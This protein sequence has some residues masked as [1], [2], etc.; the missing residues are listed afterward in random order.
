MTTVIQFKITTL[1]NLHVG[2]G[3]QNFGVVDNLVQKDPITEIPMINSS[4][5]K[6]SIRDHFFSILGKDMTTLRMKS[7]F[8]HSDKDEAN[9]GEVKFLQASL[10]ALP[11]RSNK[12]LYFLA[13]TPQILKEYIESY[14]ILTKKTLS[15]TIPII[16]EGKSI[17]ISTLDNDCYVEDYKVDE[18]NNQ[19][20]KDLSDKLFDGAP[21]A[22]IKDDV[23]KTISLPIITRNKIAKTQEDDNN[24]FY[25]E[26]IP[27]RTIF[28]SYMI[29][30]SKANI[31]DENI[32]NRFI[33]FIDEIKKENIQIGA[34]ASIGYGLCRFE[35]MSYE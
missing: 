18:N 6:G 13:T 2:S 1:S 32:K 25:E 29:T 14:K 35:E 23:F 26:I 10:L 3:E 17:Y 16:A 11:V 28:Y 8:G 27:R 33:D 5:L 34:N 31:A 30:P 19:M 22:L 7:I 12:Q 20:L 15:L 24:L 9:A 21:L 4:S